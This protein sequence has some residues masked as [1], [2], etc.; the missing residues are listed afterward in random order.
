MADQ[1]VTARAD[2]G[3]MADGVILGRQVVQGVEDARRT[4]DRLSEQLGFIAGGLRECC[5]EPGAVALVSD[6][7]ETAYER[8]GEMEELAQQVRQLVEAAAGACPILPDTTDE[9]ALFEAINAAQGLGR[10]FI[11]NAG[12]EAARIYRERFA[13]HPK[14]PGGQEEAE[15]VTA[16]LSGLEGGEVAHA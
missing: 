6:L 1:Q 10:M 15:A 2:G 4:L 7:A 12:L 8:A 16:A 14:V 9:R 3:K 5:S 11:V 13:D